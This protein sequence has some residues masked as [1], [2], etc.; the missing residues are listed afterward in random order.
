MYL[1]RTKKKLEQEENRELEEKRG[2][3]L[4]REFAEVCRIPDSAAASNAGKSPTKKNVQRSPKDL[5]LEDLPDGACYRPKS[6]LQSDGKGE[7]AIKPVEVGY[8]IIACGYF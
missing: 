5:R 2:I 6:V 7:T 1:M 8:I 4:E 3:L